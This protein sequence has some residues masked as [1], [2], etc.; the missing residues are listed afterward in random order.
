MNACRIC[1][2]ETSNVF[3][4]DLK[5]VPICE[6]CAITIFIQQAIWYS[7][8]KIRRKPTIKTIGVIAHNV[9]DFQNW[10]KAKKHKSNNNTRNTIREYTYRNNCYICIISPNHCR[11]YMFD[12]LIETERAYC[13]T[14]YLYIKDVAKTRLKPK[15]K[16][17]KQN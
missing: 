12:K 10:R 14:N 5:Q 9:E 6:R 3:N 1:D 2:N 13:N 4:I 16:Y 17:E 11:G 15:G 8:Q 7:N